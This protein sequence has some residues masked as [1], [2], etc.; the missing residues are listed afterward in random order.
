MAHQPK[1][2]SVSQAFASVREAVRS[3][4][5]FVHFDLGLDAAQTQAAKSL[6]VTKDGNYDNFG[7]LG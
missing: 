1:V 4:E 2:P 5:S 7:A 3:E 6:L